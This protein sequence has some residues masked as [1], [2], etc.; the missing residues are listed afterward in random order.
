MATPPLIL[1][2]PV[3]HE[4][5]VASP[6]L[7]LGRLRSF[8]K[9]S[10]CG[11]DGFRA[12]H[13]LDALSGS[14]AAIS[15]DLIASITD[16]VNLWLSVSFPSALGEFVASAPLTPLIE[17]GGSLRPIAVGIIWRRLVSKCAA[18]HVGKEVNAY[19]GDYQFGMLDLS[20]TFNLIDHT[21]MLSE[22]RN[23]CPSISRWVELCYASPARL[24]YMDHV[25]SFS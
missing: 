1:S 25:L 4:A 24:Y 19:L 16:V 12:Q 17:L 2:T 22:V 5:I 11:R 10:S 7:V 14:A 13:F 8:P 23:L 3:A 9:G 18:T 6:D 20:N 21:A 15:D